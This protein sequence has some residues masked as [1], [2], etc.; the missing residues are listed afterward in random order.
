MLI[1]Q[2]LDW[3][4]GSVA[5]APTLNDICH[6]LFIS[7]NS[8]TDNSIVSCLHVL[9]TLQEFS[10]SSFSKHVHI[11]SYVV[12]QGLVV[13]HSKVIYLMVRSEK[14]YLFR[15]EFALDAVCF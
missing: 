5:T 6:H 14:I 15:K 7:L 2:V 10:I 3:M 11:Y 8:Y 4:D 13:R 9:V 1:V 12:G